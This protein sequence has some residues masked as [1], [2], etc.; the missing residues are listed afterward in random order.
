MHRT[1]LRRR[2][3]VLLGGGL[4]ALASAAFFL[5]AAPQAQAKGKAED[6]L[7]YAEDYESAVK[8]A[9]ARNTFIFATFHKDN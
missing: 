1:R 4:L 3:T 7:R 6:R 8:E 5:S 2:S 9:R